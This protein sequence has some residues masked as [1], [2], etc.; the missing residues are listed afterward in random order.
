M[1]KERTQTPFLLEP[2]QDG[3]P[4]LRSVESGESMHHSGGAA[5]ETEFIYKTPIEL[6]LKHLNVCHVHVLGLG[7]AYIEITW[8]IECIKSNKLKK[9]ENSLSSFEIEAG[10]VENFISWLNTEDTQDSVYDQ[11]CKH[12][13][14]EV[15]ITEIKEILLR[16]FGQHPVKG[17][18]R[19]HY[20]DSP[21]ANLICFDAFSN[22]TTQ[23]LWSEE[24][25]DAYVKSCANEDCIFTT[26]ACTGILKRVLKKNGFEMIP[27]YR[28][29]GWKDSTFAVR[30]IF[31]SV[32]TPY[33]TS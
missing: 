8:A 3:S 29:K 5:L 13:D 33:R 15:Q 18:L 12:L 14:S 9:N 19:A 28:F 23:E 4:T 31:K 11:I 6:A 10:L 7:L 21:K 16:N 26:Y 1:N 27:R 30:G 25:L 22:K 17:D 24:F 2:T 20:K 32:E